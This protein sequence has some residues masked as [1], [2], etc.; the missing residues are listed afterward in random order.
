M[1]NL[2]SNSQEKES[3]I[4]G[5]PENMRHAYFFT[6]YMRCALSNKLDTI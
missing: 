1:K 6:L 3:K 4:Q 2:V 5:V